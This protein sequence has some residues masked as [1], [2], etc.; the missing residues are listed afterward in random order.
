MTF[1]YLPHISLVIGIHNAAGCNGSG[2]AM[3]SYLGYR[4]GVKIA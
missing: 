1:G 2:V 4:I 3:M